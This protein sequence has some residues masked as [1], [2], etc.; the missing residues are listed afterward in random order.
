MV[1]RKTPRFV[2]DASLGRRGWRMCMI[3]VSWRKGD[4]G[5]KA[6]GLGFLV[7]RSFFLASFT[8]H[9]FSVHSFS[10]YSFF[11]L[12]GGLVSCLFR[13]CFFSSFCK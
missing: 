11:F 6:Q 12:G 5:G 4:A 8:S 2:T 1:V 7:A 13:F 10:S 3:A 9:F